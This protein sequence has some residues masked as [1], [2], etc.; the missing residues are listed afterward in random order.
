MIYL[1]NK[2]SAHVYRI[3]V[4]I[5]YSTFKTKTTIFVGNKYYLLSRPSSGL[6]GYFLFSTDINNNNNNIL[7]N[8]FLNHTI[9]NVYCSALLHS[10]NIFLHLLYFL[11]NPEC[12]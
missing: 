4:I 5:V 3:F 2:N 6:R 12:T 9:T 8:I 7:I 1:K 10:K 11:F